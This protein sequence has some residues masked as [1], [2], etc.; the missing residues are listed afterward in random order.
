MGARAAARLHLGGWNAAPRERS[1][2]VL[3]PRE[4]LARIVPGETTV[5][6]VV[7]LCGPDY[8]V[9]ERWPEPGRRTLVYR[10]QRVQ[11]QTRRLFGW[12]SAVRHLEVERHEVVIEVEGEQVRDL[13]ASVRRARLPAGEQP[14][15]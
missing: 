11:P 5:D 9:L 14:G 10:G 7:A 6:Q 3:L 12:L 2:G 15:P 1:S 8:E 4:T 13:H